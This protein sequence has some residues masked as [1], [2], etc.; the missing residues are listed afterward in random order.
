MRTT[1]PLIG[2]ITAYLAVLLGVMAGL[3]LLI[4]KVL[5][6]AFPFEQEDGIDRAFASHRSGPGNDVS[7][8]LSWLG[9]TFVVIV[10]MVL[11]AI[12]FRLIFHRWRESAF[13]VLAVSAQALIFLLTQKLISRQRPLVP[14]LDESPPT[15]S[16]PSGHTGAATA[17]YVG[18]AVVVVWRLRG[19]PWRW[20]ALGLLLMVPLGVATARLYRGM[21]HPSD[22]VTAFLNGGLCVLILARTLLFAVLPDGLARRLDGPRHQNEDPAPVRT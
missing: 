5:E 17:L 2:R 21:H 20:P 1:G 13:L 15:S 11:V 12:A 19:S 8:V 4:T 9:S 18:I 6:H 7:G 16:F 22:V 3:G 10:V 14:H